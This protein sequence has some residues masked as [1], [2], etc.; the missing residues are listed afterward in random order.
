MRADPAKTSPTKASPAKTRLG[1]AG[2][3]ALTGSRL[4]CRNCNS[5]AFRRVSIHRS[6]GLN[7][8]PGGL[9]HRNA[10]FGERYGGSGVSYGR[11][12]D[13][14]AVLG[15][16]VGA[17]GKKWRDAANPATVL[18]AARAR[19]AAGAGLTATNRIDTCLTS[20][21][22]KRRRSSNPGGVRCAPTSVRNPCW[23]NGPGRRRPR[24]KACRFFKQTKDR[25]DRQIVSV[26]IN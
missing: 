19:A 17:S 12:I 20:I 26:I 11:G 6:S 9:N 7:R 18:I 24:Q 14:A 23:S 5:L 13:Q 1:S 3:A 25:R 15:R 2:Q 4:K 8:R 10:G 21:G 22:P 16:F